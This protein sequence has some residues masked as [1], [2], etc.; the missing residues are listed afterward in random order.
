MGN[1]MCPLLLHERVKR[2]EFFAVLAG[3]EKHRREIFV[4]IGISADAEKGKQSSL[5]LA[6]LEL[7]ANLTQNQTAPPH[8]SQED[9]LERKIDLGEL[10]DIGLEGRKVT[11][12]FDPGRDQSNGTLPTSNIPPKLVPSSLPGV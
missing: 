10:D 8:V 2:E 5:I 4:D 9:R 7:V 3:M 6:Q 11:R 1:N 12:Q